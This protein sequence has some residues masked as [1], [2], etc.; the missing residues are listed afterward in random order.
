M[1][2]L[3]KWIS[4]FLSIAIL[5]APINISTFAKEATNAE[6]KSFGRTDLNI[7]I[8]TDN[9]MEYTYQESGKNLIIFP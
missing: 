5:V 8:E 9:Y 3:K 7:L 6:E 2:K 1:L 4:A